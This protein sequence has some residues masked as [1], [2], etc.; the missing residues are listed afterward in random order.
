MITLSAY[1]KG[2][3]KE[4]ADEL[5]AEI[6]ANAQNTVAK[7]NELLALAEADTGYQFGGVASG[8]RPPEIN[9]ATANAASHSKHLTGEA[10]DVRDPLGHLDAW[11]VAN[12]DALEKIG[13]WMESPSKTEGWTHLQT[14]PPR[15]GS[16]V[17]L[18]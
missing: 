3:D 9:D 12:Q 2:R 1:W 16:R 15:S 5:T 18:P 10:C 6:Q 13:L 4:Y 14:V 17:F 7:V 8:W 11:C